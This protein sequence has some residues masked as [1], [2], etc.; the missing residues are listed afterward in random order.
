MDSWRDDLRTLGIPLPESFDLDDWLARLRNRTATNTTSLVGVTSVLFLLAER[1]RNERVQD[2]WDAL[3]YCSTCLSV[4]YADIHPRT[5]A[6]KIIGT[7]LMTI[8]PAMA[9]KMLDGSTAPAEATSLKPVA[10]EGT[11]STQAEI[12][13]TLK[14]ILEC[15]RDGR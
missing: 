4:G 8:G 7:A 6:G 15:I 14:Q 5:P 3:L 10:T 9:A 1:G 11:P 12:L 13:A 2:I